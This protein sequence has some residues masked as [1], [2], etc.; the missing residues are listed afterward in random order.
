MSA[1]D[2]LGTSNIL[3]SSRNMSKYLCG[4]LKRPISISFFS[5]FSSVSNTS[6]L[7]ELYFQDFVV[8]LRVKSLGRPFNFLGQ[9]KAPIITLEDII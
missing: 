3:D 1:E 2:Y 9:Y 8:F 5:F 4:G 6:M 7:S